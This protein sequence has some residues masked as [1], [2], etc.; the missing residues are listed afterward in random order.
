VNRLQE[1]DGSDQ[2]GQSNSGSLS[3]SLFNR[4]IL[5]T[6]LFG[7]ALT[8]LFSYAISMNSA[9]GEYLISVDPLEAFMQVSRGCFATVRIATRRSLVSVV[10]VFFVLRFSRV[11]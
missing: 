10:E 7:L 11:Y 9:W 2:Q 4:K 3:V 6:R 1:G 5:L 8:F